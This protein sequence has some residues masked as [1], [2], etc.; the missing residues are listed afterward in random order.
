MYILKVKNNDGNK[1]KSSFISIKAA[2]DFLSD[3]PKNQEITSFDA[4]SGKKHI[5]L[6]GYSIFFNDQTKPLVPIMAG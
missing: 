5:D 4:V 6:M 3:L 1:E 2:K